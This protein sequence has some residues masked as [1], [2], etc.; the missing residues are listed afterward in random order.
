[1]RLILNP[2]EGISTDG[3]EN[4][5]EERIFLGPPLKRLLCQ[6]HVHRVKIYFLGHRQETLSKHSSFSQNSA[7]NQSASS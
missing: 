3:E 5:W 2:K 7:W 6:G 1:M 4:L